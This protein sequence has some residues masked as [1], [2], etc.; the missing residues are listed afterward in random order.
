MPNKL[1]NWERKEEQKE[2]ECNTS[3]YDTFHA[4]RQGRQ[5]QSKVKESEFEEEV[6]KTFQSLKTFT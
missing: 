2:E 4:R 3:G 6:D 5:K 1:A